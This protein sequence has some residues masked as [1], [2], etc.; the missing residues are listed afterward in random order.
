MIILSRRNRNKHC[1]NLKEF[2]CISQS[3]YSSLSYVI[4]QSD[5]QTKGLKRARSKETILQCS[6]LMLSNRRG[7]SID[8][9]DNIY[10]CL[11]GF[12]LQML[13]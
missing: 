5:F 13:F 3:Y 12:F 10:G 7:H 2:N 1:L 8:V 4:G 11:R 6:T 9:S